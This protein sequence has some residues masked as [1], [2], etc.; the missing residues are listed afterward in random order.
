MYICIYTNI[1]L[2][3][4]VLI[5]SIDNDT[6]AGKLKQRAS[7][8]VQS[9]FNFDSDTQSDKINNHIP[10]IRSIDLNM[11]YMLHTSNIVF[12]N[13]FRFAIKN[14]RFCCRLKKI[15]IIKYF[16][17]FYRYDYISFLS[18]ILQLT[19]TMQ[20]NYVTRHEY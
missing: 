11:M 5:T 18:C 14:L 7:T 8:A 13:Y 1:A 17:L 16:Q 10:R 2:I 20:L 12:N 3:R 6:T 19:G 4:I 9:Y 15:V